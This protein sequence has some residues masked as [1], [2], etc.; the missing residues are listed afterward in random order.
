[1][2]NM[3]EVTHKRGVVPDGCPDQELNAVAELHACN[4][5]DHPENFTGSVIISHSIACQHG[6]AL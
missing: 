2:K 1:M 6:V 3:K 4:A 5:T